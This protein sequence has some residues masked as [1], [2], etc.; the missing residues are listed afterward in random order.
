VNNDEKAKLCKQKRKGQVVW[1]K[2]RRSCFGNKRERARFC[3][4]KRERGPG[5]RV[6]IRE[7]QVV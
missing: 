1:T 5:Y 7:G 6:N 3:K 4:Q 2:E